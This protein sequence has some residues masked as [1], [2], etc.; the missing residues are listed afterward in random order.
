MTRVKYA[1]IRCSNNRKC[2]PMP[3][4]SAS[5]MTCWKG[6]PFY[7]ECYGKM[8]P[9]C[10]HWSKLTAGERG[11]DFAMLQ[12]ELRTL[13]YGVAWRYA[14]VGDLPGVDGA[15]NVKQA[16]QLVRINTQG[17]RLGFAYTHKPVLEPTKQAAANRTVIQEMNRDGFTVNLSSEGLAKADVL[18]GLGI[19]PV[20]TVVPKHGTDPN[21]RTMRTPAG[22]RVLRCH[23]EWLEKPAGCKMQCTRCGGAAGPLCARQRDDIIG[24]TA[25]AKIKKVEAV[26]AAMEQKY[27]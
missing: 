10:L 26:I 24:F 11:A 8:W 5:Q 27:R 13:P 12:R 9:I 6:C 18:A 16:R 17:N 25:H 3:I 20:V 22:R 1:L 2:G 23:A 14:D 4:V 21:W 19:A 15:I 7:D